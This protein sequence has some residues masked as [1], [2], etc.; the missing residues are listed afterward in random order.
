MSSMTEIRV[1]NLDDAIAE[2]LEAAAKHAG[3]SLESHVREILKEASRAG[4][5]DFPLASDWVRSGFDEVH[6]LIPGRQYL[7]WAAMIPYRITISRS[8]T[9]EEP[10]WNTVIEEGVHVTDPDGER[11]SVW[12][13][14]TDVA[15]R[16]L[17]TSPGMALRDAIRWVSEYAGVDAVA[18]VRALATRTQNLSPRLRQIVDQLDGVIKGTKTFPRE[19]M[20]IWTTRN[21]EIYVNQ[22]DDLRGALMVYRRGEDWSVSDGKATYFP[23]GKEGYEVIREALTELGVKSARDLHVP[24]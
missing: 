4:L 17:G 14:A 24:S 5:G 10:E 20:V 22:V 18:Q 7:A 13:R 11:L 8:L 3:R 16:L 6:E 23:L 2:A 1:R 15:Q 21:Y 9:G 12:A 19:N